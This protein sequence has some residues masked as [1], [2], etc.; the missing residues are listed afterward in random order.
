MKGT[1]EW[2]E[3]ARSTFLLL[4]PIA[5]HL[6]EELW[7]RWEFGGYVHLQSWPTFDPAALVED[8]VQMAVQVNGKVRG[9]I[10]VAKDATKE[11]VLALARAEENVVRHIGGGEVAR[12]IVVP[13]KLVSFVV[14]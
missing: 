11:E 1:A 12:A 6:A 4:A 14:K 5:P 10:A 13:G 9:Q 2:R 7:H 3:A 8:T